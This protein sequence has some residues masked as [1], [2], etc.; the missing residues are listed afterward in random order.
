MTVPVLMS[1]RLIRALQQA[2]VVP[3]TCRR[4]VIDAQL[5]KTVVVHVEQV[6]SPRLLEVVPGL[7]GVQVRTVDA[8]EAEAG[9]KA[10][11]K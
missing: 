10:A 7:E 1:D 9:G 11:V 4:V 6:G 3:G 8:A 2:G 5:A